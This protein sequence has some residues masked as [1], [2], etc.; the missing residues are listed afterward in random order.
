MTVLTNNEFDELLQQ[1]RKEGTDVLGSLRDY[2]PSLSAHQQ[3]KID[4]HV[5]E[6][7]MEYRPVACYFLV[8][9]LKVFLNETGFLLKCLG[10][11]EKS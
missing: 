11:L 4:H 6:M 7:I 5:R 2:V 8:P 1:S 9:G 3:K 10:L